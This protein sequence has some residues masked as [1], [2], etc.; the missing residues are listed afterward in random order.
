M[1]F[2]LQYLRRRRQRF[3]VGTFLVLV[4]HMCSLLAGV[5]WILTWLSH[6]SAQ[7]RVFIGDLNL[8]FGLSN[9][10]AS[11]AVADGDYFSF[12]LSLPCWLIVLL[13][14]VCELFVYANRRQIW[15]S[16]EE[17]EKSNERS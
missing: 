14:G 12:Q 5:A 4:L 7:S 11:F 16:E 9:H 2:P 10:S 6:G 15:H 3:Q 8:R 17:L 13:L 1:V